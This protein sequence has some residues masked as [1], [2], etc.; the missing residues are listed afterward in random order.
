MSL[1][2]PTQGCTDILFLSS[3]TQL[4]RHIITNAVSPTNVASTV[5]SSV[6][7][8]TFAGCVVYMTGSTPPTAGLHIMLQFVNLEFYTLLAISFQESWPLALMEASPRF[9]HLSLTVGE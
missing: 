9:S 1:T 5:C 2:P 4:G 3:V 6:Q 8:G 7:C